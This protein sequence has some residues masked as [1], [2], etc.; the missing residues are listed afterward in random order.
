QSRHFEKLD[1]REIGATA[2]ATHQED[3]AVLA[4]DGERDTRW[5][6]G[7]PRSPGM[8]LEIALPEQQKIRG[9]RLSMG[10]WCH[11]AASDLEITVERNSGRRT[12]VVS[13]RDY[14][15]L[16]YLH[17]KPCEWQAVFRPT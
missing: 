9:L 12:V 6:T 8:Y 10:D 17:E 3:G 13:N 11:D 14:Q 1:L 15:A 7:G 2:T 4:I 5:G 16:R